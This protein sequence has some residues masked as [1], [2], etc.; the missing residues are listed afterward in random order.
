MEFI[1][2][3]LHC[4]TYKY[5]CPPQMPCIPRANGIWQLSGNSIESMEFV[6]SGDFRS[7]HHMTSRHI[8]QGMSSSTCSRCYNRSICD[9]YTI[10]ICTYTNGEFYNAEHSPTYLETTRKSPRNW[11]CRQFIWGQ[12]VAKSW[13]HRNIRTQRDRKAGS[14][15]T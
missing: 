4:A 2:A 7:S 10:L 9:N 5:V 12:G 11:S 8:K 13:R 3:W 14:C 6:E 1:F 15:K